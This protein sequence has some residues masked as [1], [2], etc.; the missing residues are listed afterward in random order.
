MVVAN[1][2]DIEVIVAGN[3][4]FH[5]RTVDLSKEYIRS[6]IVYGELVD[7]QVGVA[8]KSGNFVVTLYGCRDVQSWRRVDT[9]ISKDKDPRGYDESI[10]YYHWDSEEGKWVF[11]R[12]ENLVSKKPGTGKVVTTYEGLN[13]S[14]DVVVTQDVEPA[15][16]DPA[17]TLDKSMVLGT[18]TFK[19]GD[20]AGC[21]VNMRTREFD[22]VSIFNIPVDAEHSKNKFTG[23][24]YQETAKSTEQ[25]E[26]FNLG[27][28]K[29]S[30]T[31]EAAYE[32]EGIKTVFGSDTVVVNEGEELV[33]NFDT[34]ETVAFERSGNDIIATVS[35]VF[36][37]EPAVELGKVTFTNLNKANGSDIEGI[38]IKKGNE[39]ITARYLAV[40]GN[41]QGTGTVYEVTAVKNKF[42]G[43]FY[44]EYANSTAANETFSLGTGDDKINF[45]TEDEGPLKDF[46]KDTVN[47]SA[48]E[49][50]TLN[51]AE[52]ASVAY[53]YEIKSNDVI[54]K[55]TRTTDGIP[56]VVET[57]GTVTL[58]NCLK[59][60]DTYGNLY[61]K[62]GGESK[63]IN[64]IL[65]EEGITTYSGYTKATKKTGTLFDETFIGSDFADTYKAVGGDDMIYGG[66]GDD[67]LYSGGNGSKTFQFA[68]GDASGRKGDTIYNISANDKIAFGTF[69]GTE[70]DPTEGD[71]T[72]IVFDK[73]GNN[74]ILTHTDE[75]DVKD[76][77]TFSNYFKKTADYDFKVNGLSIKDNAIINVSGKGNVAG[78]MLS[79]D[80]TIKGKSTITT[81]NGDDVIHLTCDKGTEDEENIIIT[82]DTIVINGSGTKYLVKKESET[83][84]YEYGFGVKTVKFTTADSKNSTVNMELGVN[85]TEPDE[86]YLCGK[87]N[88][89]L[90]VEGYYDYKEGEQGIEYAT[91]GTYIIKDYFKEDSFVSENITLDDEA[92]TDRLAATII[93]QEGTKGKKA[94]YNDTKYSDYILGANKNDTYNLNAVG[95]DRVEDISGNDTYKLKN[96]TNDILTLTDKAGNDKLIISDAD[97]CN[98]FF[99]LSVDD[100]GAITG[101][102]T[103][104][105]LFSDD[106]LSE[107]GVINGGVVINDY[108]GEYSEGHISMGKGCI[109]TIKAGDTT[110]SID[111]D[112]V[113]A[114]VA[115][116][117]HENDYTSAME[118]FDGEHGEDAAALI[119]VY[120]GKA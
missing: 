68:E 39:D 118:V 105:R 21:P 43:T 27:I 94:T 71:L 54:I 16:K 112:T 30:I 52:D 41:G 13:S 6:F 38:T 18:F 99:G 31:F 104:L 102:G 72:D 69:D 100:D 7:G 32:N 47:F 4:K 22:D 77:I 60:A 29:D 1:P 116:W 91:Y 44:D 56:P 35:K 110:I 97:S 76:K 78:T 33:I 3:T 120:M 53:S 108:L 2:E 89:D 66:K 88:N 62:K 79:D 45:P 9:F 107:E 101:V 36:E 82:N 5:N 81:G 93:Y 50:L 113:A 37:D 74:L 23:G 24:V 117:L 83:A 98:Y 65:K 12:V 40:R 73:S 17:T 51:F 80:I 8:E 61:M 87:N 84:G 19:K 92:L 95:L 15:S 103:I 57:V 59:V 90:V 42:T 86:G 28:N 49:I 64:E 10:S 119:N 58:K 46:G 70:F 106:G 26:I 111:F 11:D 55:A 63:T 114:N 67:K 48:G 115:A 85:T 96:F 25:N 20:P 14:G 75:D 34:E 109:E